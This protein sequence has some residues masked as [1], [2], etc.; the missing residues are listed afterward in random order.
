MR[1]HDICGLPVVD[2][3]KRPVGILTNRDLRFEKNLEQPV[4][5]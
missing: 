5:R 2:A 1:Q 4:A 3:D